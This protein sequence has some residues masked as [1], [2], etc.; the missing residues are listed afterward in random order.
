VA[1]GDTRTVTRTG[2]TIFA[3][4]TDVITAELLSRRG[5]ITGAIHL[6]LVVATD[7][8]ATLAV[9]GA[10][11]V[12]RAM[13]TGFTQISVT[14]PVSTLEHLGSIAAATV[15]RTLYTVL[16]LFAQTNHVPTES[17]ICL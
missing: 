3:V 14:S 12:T 17:G 6:T 13:I 9:S 8:I 2:A 7:T 15:I 5:A 11:T 4:I 16:T 1:N 10:S